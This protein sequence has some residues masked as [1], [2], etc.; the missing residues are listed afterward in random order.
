MAT[1]RQLKKFVANTCGAMAAEIILARAAFPV[2]ERKTVYDIISKIAALQNDTIKKVSLSFD[3][4]PRDFANKSEYNKARRTYFATAYTKL[5][6]Y[7]DGAVADIV[8][9]M[10]AALPAEVRETLKG[11]AAE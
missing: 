5:L 3:K 9:E 8:K 6:S 4:A 10:N 1:K 7:F 11:V 2:I